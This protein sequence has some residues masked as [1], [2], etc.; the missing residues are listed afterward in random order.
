MIELSSRGFAAFLSLVNRR[1]VVELLEASYL[2]SL[3]GLV[4]RALK[5]VA[6]NCGHFVLLSWAFLLAR[7][8]G[9]RRMHGDFRRH[10]CA[11]A[12]HLADR[13]FLCHA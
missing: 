3:H 8:D 4:K 10:V 2:V 5:L 7:V 9:W 6:P 12:L 13:A 11:R 1:I